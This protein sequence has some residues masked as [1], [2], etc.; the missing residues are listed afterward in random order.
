MRPLTIGR[1]GERGAVSSRIDREPARSGSVLAFRLIDLV[2]GKWRRQ[3]RVQILR[4]RIRRLSSTQSHRR[5]VTDA[6]GGSGR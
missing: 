1:A 2:E 4:F 5:N 3:F 6:T